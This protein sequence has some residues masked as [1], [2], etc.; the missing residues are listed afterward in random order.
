[1]PAG[2][3]RAH[4]LVDRDP[5]RSDRWIAGHHIAD[6]ESLERALHEH[7]GRLAAR[8]RHEK[9]AEEDK[10]HAAEGSQHEELQQP[11]ADHQEGAHPSQPRGAGGGSVAIASPPP[12]PGAKQAAPVE[13]E[14]G[15][16]VEDQEGCIG[17]GEPHAATFDE[18][19][20]ACGVERE[21][22]GT[23]EDGEA[24]A[25]ERAGDGDFRFH[26]RRR[27]VTPKARDSAEDPQR[28]AVHLHAEPP[29]DEGVA[30]LVSEQ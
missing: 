8:R 13:R 26:S 6:E 25:D 28:D 7:L 21:G 12:E 11:E 15:D 10:P 22:R 9:P 3:V 23:E 14:G 5:S 2:N 27:N 30:H 1:M 4:E 29:G 18:R 17:E 20:S 19:R 16:E 24:K